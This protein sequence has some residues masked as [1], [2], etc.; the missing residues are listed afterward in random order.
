MVNGLPDAADLEAEA[1]AAAAARRKKRFRNL[2]I[3]AGGVAVVLCS[4]ILMFVLSHPRRCRR[5]APRK[6]S[7]GTVSDV[8]AVSGELGVAPSDGG[9]VKRQSRIRK[10]RGHHLC[11]R[12][13]GTC[14]RSWQRGDVVEITTTVDPVSH[15]VVQE[16]HATRPGKF[17][18]GRLRSR[19]DAVRTIV[20]ETGDET[21][22][23]DLK[24][25]V[26][27]R[28]EERSCLNGQ[29]TFQEK[30]VT[31][32][33]LHPGDRLKVQYDYQETSEQRGQ[34]AGGAAAGRAPRRPG[35]GF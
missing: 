18:T 3:L 28:P 33:S 34:Q 9:A 12:R 22:H 14:S 17:A 26:P 4:L 2:S 21:N 11:Q 27:D 19:D 31:L 5:R 20:M 30:P 35:R 23:Q 7:K 16:I 10:I 25:F 1:E 15:K 6:P 29:S 8:F 24:I 32:A 13:S